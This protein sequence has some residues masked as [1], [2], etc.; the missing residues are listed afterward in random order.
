MAIDVLHVERGSSAVER[1]T[2]NQGNPGS[3]PILIP[4]RSFG[5]CVLRS[6]HDAPVHSVV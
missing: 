1:R 6:L 2:H 4:F 3:T 5:I